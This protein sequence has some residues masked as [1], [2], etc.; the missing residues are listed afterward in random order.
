MKKPRP[1]GYAFEILREVLRGHVILEAIS[2][3]NLFLS[4]LKILWIRHELDI[5]AQ[6]HIGHSPVKFDSAPGS[7]KHA[8]ISDIPPIVGYCSL[9][10]IPISIRRLRKVSTGRN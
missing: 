7:R 10:P 4:A 6:P 3:K 1:V 5:T 9:V 8:N 2:Q